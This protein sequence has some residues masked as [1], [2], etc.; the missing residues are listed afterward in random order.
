MFKKFKMWIAFLLSVALIVGCFPVHVIALDFEKAGNSETTDISSGMLS[1]SQE[2][3]DDTVIGEIA[4][5]VSLRD[6]NTKHFR[7]SDG[8]YEA[9]IYPQPVHGHLLFGGRGE[10]LLC[11]PGTSVQDLQA[12]NRHN[13]KKLPKRRSAITLFLPR[14]RYPKQKSS[15]ELAKILQ[16]LCCFGF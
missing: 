6:E 7:L 5:V 3:T 8:T 2:Y 14:P 1:Q 9:V 10:L 15:T 16:V 13:A 12:G 4:E 11:Q